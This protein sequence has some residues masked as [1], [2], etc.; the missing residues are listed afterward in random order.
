MCDT[1][2]MTRRLRFA[3]TALVSTA[4]TLASAQIHYHLAPNL[5]D[6]RV[7]V[8]MTFDA[9]AA[10]TTIEL[11]AWAPGSYRLNNVAETVI[12]VRATVGGLAVTPSL[13]SRGRWTISTSRGAHVSFSYVLPLNVTAGSGHLAGPSTYMYVTGRKRDACE[14]SVEIP[15]GGRIV[16]GLDEK[17][18]QWLAPNYDVLADNPITVG[19]FL[20]DTYRVAG[21]THY[22]CLYGTARNTVD[23]PYLSRACAFVS[24][25]ECDLFGG[26]PYRK[27]VWHFRT[28]EAADGA[29]GL[30]HLNSTEIS[31]ASGMGP[32]VI[33]VYAHEFFHAWNVKRIRSRALGPFDYTQLPQTGA[34]WWL[35]GVT[36]YYAHSLLRRYGWTSDKQYYEEFARNVRSLRGNRARFTNS[37]YDASYRVRDAA[38]GRGNSQGLG[39]SY[40]DAGH[41]IGLIFD[42]ELLSVSHG[43]YSIDDVEKALWAMC[44]DDQPGFEEG[45]L[46]RQLVRFGGDELGDVY[47]R[48]VMTA[49][50]LPIEAELA[51][52]GCQLSEKDVVT[53]RLPAPTAARA[54]R[55]GMLVTLSDGPLKDGD[56]ITMINGVSVSYP[57]THQILAGWN[58]ALGKLK[59]GD[60]IVLSLL[61]DKT[62]VKVSVKA[63]KRTTKSLVIDSVASPTPAQL[64]LRRRLF[65]AHRN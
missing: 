58:E 22:I 62:E 46:R 21:R 30:E 41:Q 16:T 52:I 25:M 48:V 60:V 10:E 64:D 11:P 28:N 3:L 51:K 23:R 18:G 19:D 35:E 63:T 29:G 65:S 34:L 31:M 37:P 13:K 6:A 17:G 14:L 45:E 7:K 44:R 42:I 12:E 1:S 38:G 49:A 32:G 2:R 27:Y 40:Y 55:K 50:E 61:R 20:L 26:A 4:V 54:A 43:R 24:A 59:E 36:D 9:E 39:I 53:T 47:D 33:G 57:T 15:K 56:V 5:T 8:T